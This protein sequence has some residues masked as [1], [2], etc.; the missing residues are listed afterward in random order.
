MA[1]TTYSEDWDVREVEFH[2][3][4]V[5]SDISQ[6]QAHAERLEKLL[7]RKQAERD[8]KIAQLKAEGKW[9]H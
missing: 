7:S 1:V 3:Q 4:L 5:R 6:L 8:E 9:H 2:L